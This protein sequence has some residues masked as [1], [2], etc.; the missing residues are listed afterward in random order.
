MSEMN[1]QEK[2][3]SLIKQ[4]EG[5]RELFLKCSGAIEILIDMKKQ[6]EKEDTKDEK[7]AVLDIDKKK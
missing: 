2:I 4:Q 5:Y 7:P 6:V 3:D 1:L